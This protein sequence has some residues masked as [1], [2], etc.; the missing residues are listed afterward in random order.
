MTTQGPEDGRATPPQQVRWTAPT[1][2]AASR[3]SVPTPA[4]APTTGLP[5]GDRPPRSE[6]RTSQPQP[7]PRGRAGTVLALVAV[8]LIA[9]LVGGV[10]GAV[11]VGRE[12][13]PSNTVSQPDVGRVAATVLPSVVTLKVGR[14]GTGSGF[15]FREDGYILTNSH[16][17]SAG[18]GSGPDQAVVAVFS[19]GSQLPARLVGKDASYDL[20]VLKVDRSGL[21]PLLFGNSE[22]VQVGDPVIAVGAPLG[23]QS[24]VTTGI[25][26]ALERPVVAGG[27]TDERSYINAVQTD[28]AINPGNSGGPLMDGRGQVIG[29]NTANARV[30]GSSSLGA[31]GSIGVGF[32]IPADTAE[33]AAKELIDKGRVTHPTLGARLDE[34]FA[35]PG[36]RVADG[37]VEADGPAAKAGI[38]GGDVILA[39]DGRR[40]TD[41]TMLTVRVRS[42]AVGDSLEL[43]VRSDGRGERTVRATLSAA[44]D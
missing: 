43:S 9:G 31:G 3:P 6:D 10:G 4:T 33:R 18:A 35:G 21:P 11:L 1:P 38:K 8:A 22:N 19:D 23:L 20:A 14:S 34:G 5:Q 40:I 30:R 37:G 2:R 16:V 17:A 36:A 42:K 28:A 25:V 39:L 13:E 26:S 44:D 15:V 7:P 24:T 41:A 12:D 29:V 32:A 27:S